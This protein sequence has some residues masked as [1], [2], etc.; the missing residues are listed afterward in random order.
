MGE[1]LAVASFGGVTACMSRPGTRING[2]A[3]PWVVFGASPVADGDLS[4]SVIQWSDTISILAG[5]LKHCVKSSIIV[6]RFATNRS[7]C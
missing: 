5:A 2:D 4:F 1:V 3:N 6:F 7:D